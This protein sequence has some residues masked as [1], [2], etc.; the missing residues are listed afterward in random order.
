MVVPIVI[1]DAFPKAREFLLKLFDFEFKFYVLIPYNIF[2][3]ML[4]IRTSLG[5]DLYRMLTAKS[6]SAEEIFSSL[7]LTYETNALEAGQI[8]F[9]AGLPEGILNIIFGFDT[10][11]GAPLWSHMDMDKVPMSLGT[12]KAEQIENTSEVKEKIVQTVMP[13]AYHKY[14]S[15]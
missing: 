8:K 12:L 10:T 2:T 13:R 7:N 1:K 11:A 4:L 3:I 9:M 15:W 6:T 5:E 14:K